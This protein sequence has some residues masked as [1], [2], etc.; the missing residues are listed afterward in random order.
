MSEIDIDHKLR[1]AGATLREAR[2]NAS[3]L[4]Q[5]KPGK[6]VTI[7]SAFGLFLDVSDRLHRFAPSDSV[8]GAYWLNGKE[9]QFTNAQVIRDQIET[10]NLY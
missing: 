2:L 10:S 1:Y 8:G 4:S 3:K 9:K 7:F 5:E 6:Y